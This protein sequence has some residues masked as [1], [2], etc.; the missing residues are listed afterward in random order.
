MCCADMCGNVSTS[1]N[2][3]LDL[4][5]EIGDPAESIEDCLRMFTSPEQLD[6]NNMC[7]C[8]K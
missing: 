2:E 8:S 7:D 1:D 6:K 4:S 3:I 5:L